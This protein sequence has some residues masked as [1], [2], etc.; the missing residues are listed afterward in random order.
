MLLT[1]IS[2]FITYL[3]FQESTAIIVA[4]TW[5]TSP[6]AQAGSRFLIN[7]NATGVKIGNASTP[8]ATITFA[9]A[10]LAT[11]NLAYG[12]DNYEGDDYIAIEM[13]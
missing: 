12:V 2:Y 1:F 3:L 11:P 7:A 5:V 4:P 8:T 6:Y 10:F 13:Y 9:T